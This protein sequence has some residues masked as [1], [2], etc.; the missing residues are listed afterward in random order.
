MQINSN[1]LI[2]PSDRNKYGDY[3]YFVYG[4][5]KQY[6]PKITFEI[7]LGPTANSSAAII[8]AHYEN[9]L[10]PENQN[11]NFNPHHYVLEL[12]A[13]TEALAKLNALPQNLYTLREGDS[14]KSENYCDLGGMIDILFVDGNHTTEFCYNDTVLPVLTNN[15]DIESGLLVYHDT[16][17]ASVKLAINMLK[18]KFDLSTFF[19]PKISVAVAKFNF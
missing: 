16:K 13:T 11:L 3:S 17:M 1:N 18:D 12:S 2:A 10:I 19:F 8:Q 7:G 5:V 15:F 6:E 9:S 4:L 14:S